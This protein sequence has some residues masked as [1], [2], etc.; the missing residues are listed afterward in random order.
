V[1]IT[2][3]ISDE[4]KVGDVSVTVHGEESR[5]PR[6]R[7]IFDLIMPALAAEFHPVRTYLRTR[8]K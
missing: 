2:I 4:A 7:R 8:L 1:K 6:S 5:P 3:V